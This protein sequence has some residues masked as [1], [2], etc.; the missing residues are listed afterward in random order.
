MADTRAL[1]PMLT[2]PITSVM[3]RLTGRLSDTLKLA[4]Q[5]II[6]QSFPATKRE[7]TSPNVTNEANNHRYFRREKAAHNGLV[8][9]SN[10]PGPTTNDDLDERDR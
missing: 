8:G 2:S 9:G 7:Q 5:P 3:R 10:P 6:D 1:P 4:A